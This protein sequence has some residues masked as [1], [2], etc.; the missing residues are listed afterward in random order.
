MTLHRKL[1]TKKIKTLFSRSA[2]ILCFAVVTIGLLIMYGYKHNEDFVDEEIL[3][4]ENSKIVEYVIPNEIKGKQSTT[5]VS[6]AGNS[7]ATGT[8]VLAV[9]TY[10]TA[11]STEHVVDIPV[12]VYHKISKPDLL[13][14]KNKRS[15]SKKYSV[16][17]DI[18]EAQMKYLEEE[19]YTPL[20]M[21]EAIQDK[22]QHTLPRNPVVVTFDDGWR[23]QYE[24]AIPVLVKFHIPATFY[25][26]TGVIGARAFM[27][28]ENLHDLVRINMEIGDHTKSHPALT[29]INISKLNEE[30]LQSKVVLER[31]LHVTVSDLAYP[32]G[33]YNDLIINEVKKYGY[34]SAR[35][36]HHALTDDFS[37]LYQIKVIYA[38]SDLKTFKELLLTHR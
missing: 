22:Q 9:S 13:F 28:W 2:I 34:I 35:S 16:Q 6:T 19:G 25:I 23:S 29:K 8:V 14:I 37:D 18:F 32:Y 5:T 15:N 21:K 4:M 38:P 17:S 24:N 12:L 33:D 36:S 3:D 11:T 1:F 7:I 30:L 31:N 27:T 26:Y 10:V 20:T